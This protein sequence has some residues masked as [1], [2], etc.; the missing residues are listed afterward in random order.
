AHALYQ[1]FARKLAHRT[2][3]LRSVGASR[4]RCINCSLASSLTALPR[5]ARSAL[6]ARAVSTVRS[7]ARSPHSLAALGRRFAHALYQ[8]FA[9]KL[10]HRTPS[11]R[12][13]GAS[14]TRCINCSLA[15]SLTALPRCARS[16]LRARAV[17]TVRSQA[18]SPHSLAA[19]GR[20]FAHAL[21]QLFA[22]KLAH[23]CSPHSVLAR[24]AQRPERGSAPGRG[25]IVQVRQPID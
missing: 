17:S 7:Q 12:S 11:L 20:R 8:L 16:A 10:A 24:P 21:Y 13:V 25:L 9:R 22:R 5:C 3:S 1:L 4:T 2:P 15:S 23:A 18:R 14:R 19:L 6:R